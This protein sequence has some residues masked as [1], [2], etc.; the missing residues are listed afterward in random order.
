M[1]RGTTSSLYGKDASAVFFVSDGK[2]R[3]IKSAEI[4][5]KLFNDPEWKY[6]TW[7]P[8]DLLDKFEYPLG[9]MIES[10]DIHPNGCL[11]K[12][13]DSPT[14]YLVS[15]GK[16]K[17][18]VSWDVFVENGYENRPIITIPKSETYEVAEMIRTLAEDL[19][20]P[21]FSVATE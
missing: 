10:S 20:S 6:V 13:P 7:V 15:Q 19:A 2:L 14:V 16:L 1:F 3:P 18:F 8:D 9:E 5:Q 17:P 12:Y 11:V 4:Y 21:S